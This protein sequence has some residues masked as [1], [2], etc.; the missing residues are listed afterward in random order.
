MVRS[1][2]SGVSG[3]KAHQ[4]R[5]D[6]IGNNIANVNTYGFK[7]SRAT[8]RDVYYQTMNTASGATANRGGT[9]PSQVGY[10]STIGSVDVLHTRS[11]FAMTDNGLDVAIAGEGFL[12]VQ[13]PDGNIFYTRAGMLNID[14]AGNLVDMS[15]NF[16]LG[17]SGDPLGKA[18]GSDKIQIGI[19]PVSP[20]TGSVTEKINGIEYTITGTN[21]NKDS[22][23]TFNFLSSNTLPLGQD[24]AAEVTTSG[25]T[26]YLNESANFTSLGDLTQ[27][28]NAAITSANKGVPHP[29]GDFKISATP[30]PTF[31]LSGKDI[32]NKDFS[33]TLGT[34]T[35]MPNSGALTSVFSIDKIGTAF[36]GNGDITGMS[37]AYN[38]TTKEYTVTMTA[39]D[40]AGGTKTY[41]GVIPE[42]AASAGTLLL[43]S[44]TGDDTI[45]IKH[46][47]WT[48]INGDAALTAGGVNETFAAGTVTATPTSP[49]KALGL[50]SKPIK[51]SGGTEGGAQTVADLSSIGIGKDGVIQGVH[52]VHGLLQLGR[53]D[54][55]TF[56]NNQGLEQ[57]GNTYFAATSN[58][59]KAQYCV[60]GSDG[61]GALAAGSLEMSNVDLSREFSDMITTQRGF[62]ANSRLITVSDEMLNELVNLKR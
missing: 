25:I 1:M 50:S 37:L 45:T 10:G 36:S 29:A 31:P 47:G 21:N 7:G 13:D 17:T 53:I 4:A 15:G 57:A 60:P 48:A 26:V 3:M 28:M 11:A 5:M 49:S 51:L 9:N 20:S 40:G 33:P 30:A 24:V 32:A 56:Q 18:P 6:V 46:P 19:D 8:F 41:T 16:V 62:Q 14:A 61:S 55:V 39:D 27:K 52:P 44:G 38:A 23:V 12:Q 43:K 58:S 2:Y 59:G 42:S 34:I 54:L 22:N 35:G